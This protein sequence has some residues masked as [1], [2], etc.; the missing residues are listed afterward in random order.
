MARKTFDFGFIRKDNNDN[1]FEIV[2]CESIDEMF[3]TI[4]KIYCF[5]D[6]DDTFT[7]CEIYAWG[8]KVEY[9]GWQPGMHYEYRFTE[10]GEAA[11]EGHFPHWEH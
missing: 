2:V 7:V 1:S 10:T 3:T 9:V 5:G 11:W 8:K 6:C 4:S